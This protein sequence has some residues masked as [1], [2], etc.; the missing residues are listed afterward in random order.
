VPVLRYEDAPE[1]QLLGISVRGLAS[2]SRGAHET[3]MYRVILAPGDELPRH[4]H[5]HEE[6]FHV[7]SGTLTA[8]LDGDPIPVDEGDTVMIP[9]GV[10]HHA[11]AGD[12]GAQVLAVLPTGAVM[13]RPDGQRLRPPWAE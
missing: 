5:D 4:H 1:F 3:V 10:A 12:D 13:I 6:V 8:F 2:P 7:L 9:P 11:V